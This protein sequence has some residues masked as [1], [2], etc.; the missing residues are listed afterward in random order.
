MILRR[1]CDSAPFLRR[2]TTTLREKTR[3]TAFSFTQRNLLL[4]LGKALD[5]FYEDLEFTIYSSTSPAELRT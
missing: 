1:T 4:T 2:V 5:G 3:N